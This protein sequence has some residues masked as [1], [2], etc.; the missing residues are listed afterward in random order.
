MNNMIEVRNE[1]NKLLEL[2]V[3]IENPP[4]LIIKDRMGKNYV[5]LCRILKTV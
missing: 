4:L 3:S 2:I 1:L 5:V